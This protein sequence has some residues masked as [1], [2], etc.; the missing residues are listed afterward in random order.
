MKGLIY[1]LLHTVEE[2]RSVR[3]VCGPQCV[4]T[5]GITGKQILSAGILD[6]MEVGKSHIFIISVRCFAEISGSFALE[7]Y[8]SFV[9]DD[10]KIVK[11]SCKENQEFLSECIVT[12][13]D[14]SACNTRATVLCT[15]KLAGFCSFGYNKNLLQII[16]VKR[17]QFVL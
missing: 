9:P 14:D 17:V 12:E 11:L 7:E 5:G 4:V 8:A 3:K 10:R 15:G 1:G 2:L 6:I 16:H 13:L